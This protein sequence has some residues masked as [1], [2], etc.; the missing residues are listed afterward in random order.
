MKLSAGG[1]V[2][3][4][5]MREEGGREEAMHRMGVLKAEPALATPAH[6]APTFAPLS[7]EPCGQP[8]P[9]RGVQTG[10]VTSLS[11]PC[12]HLQNSYCITEDR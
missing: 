12:P 8:L 1:R 11:S 3:V 9:L 7:L 5:K 4:V 2:K 6:P 10:Y